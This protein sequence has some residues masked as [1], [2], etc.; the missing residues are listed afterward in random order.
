[1]R[2]IRQYFDLITGLAE[3]SGAESVEL[4]FDP[5][6][7]ASGDVDGVFYFYDGSRL[8]FTETVAIE[9]QS[10]K[11]LSYR[12]QFIHQEKTRFRYDNA[13]HHPKLPNHP[14]HKHVGAKIVTA[15]EPMLSQVLDEVRDILDQTKNQL[16]AKPKRRRR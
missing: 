13:D 14:H 6:D 4:D 1:M 15:I 2:D 9:K 7:Q 11:K 3:S 12:Y 16:P 5:V 8:E 10:P